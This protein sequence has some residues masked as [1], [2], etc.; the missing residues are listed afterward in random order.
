L[1]YKKTFGK[2]KRSREEVEADRRHTDQVARQLKREKT[3][4]ENIREEVSPFTKFNFAQLNR[5]EKKEKLQS[6]ADNTMKANLV[7]SNRA[8]DDYLTGYD[9]SQFRGATMYGDFQ[10]LYQHL[11]RELRVNN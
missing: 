3:R 9:A 10:N 8:V 6:Q 2:D 7:L 11:T 4:Q 5:H 1:K